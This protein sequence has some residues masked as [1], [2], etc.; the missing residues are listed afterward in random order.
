MENMKEQIDY[1]LPNVDFACATIWF[2]GY[3]HE[4]L[5]AFELTSK[6]ADKIVS[7]LNDYIKT[8]YPDRD[9]VVHYDNEKFNLWN[10][11]CDD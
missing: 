6:E 1:L 11:E 4:C 7:E 5:S 9:I 10:N 2:P 8:E 3:A